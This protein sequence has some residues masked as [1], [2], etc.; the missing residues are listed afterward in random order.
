MQLECKTIVCSLRS[1][2]GVLERETSLL[3]ITVSTGGGGMLPLQANKLNEMY[4]LHISPLHLS[5]RVDD[6]DLLL[7]CDLCIAQLRAALS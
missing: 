2:F 4:R 6:A 5:L 7:A 3:K 1:S